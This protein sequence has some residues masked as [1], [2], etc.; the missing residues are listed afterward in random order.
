MYDLEG[1]FVRE[2]KSAMD[3]NRYFDENAINGSAVLKA[4]RTG[5]T[6]HGYQFSKEKL[7]YMKK[8]EVK[9]G[10]H[11]FKRK[12]GRYDEKGNLLET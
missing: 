8:F 12:V 9:K 4:I 6:L 10:S 2:F 5:Q 1:N 7:P 3:C 11:N